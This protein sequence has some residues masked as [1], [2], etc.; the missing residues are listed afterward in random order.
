MIKPFEYYVNE[1]LVRKSIP[2][3]GM[4]RSLLQKAE[5]RLR[6]VMNEKITKSESS[7]IF[8][9]IYESLREASQSLM[10]IKGYKPYSHEALIAFLKGYKML[11]DGEVNVIDSYR[12][13]R[14]SSVYKAEEISSEKCAEALE[15]AKQALPEIREKF[16][17]LTKEGVKWKIE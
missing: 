16:E 2:N 9:D 5:V 3:L 13:L 6:R 17:Q 7:I 1:N 11:N 15:F 8:E 14:N 12:M 10:E 4:A